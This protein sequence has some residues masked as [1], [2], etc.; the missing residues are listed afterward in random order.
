ML[1]QVLHWPR[2]VL[3]CQEAVYLGE[4]YNTERTKMR[5]KRAL[6]AGLPLLFMV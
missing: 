6:F 3:V 4:D 5:S 2:G 1:V